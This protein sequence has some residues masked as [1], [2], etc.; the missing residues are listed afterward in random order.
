MTG[1][2]ESWLTLRE[3]ADN[4][5]R[6]KTLERE[7]ESLVQ[8]QREL[9][10]L[11]LGC[12]TG[13]NLRYLLPRLGH[14]Q[15]WTLFDNDAALLASLPNLLSQWANTYGATMRLENN[16]IVLQAPGFDATIHTI[17]IDLAK[18]LP[19]LPL[20][21]A[22][23]VTGSALLDLTSR[24]W[25]DTLATLCVE[26]RCATLF[27]LNYDG[28]VHW[29]PSLID[30]QLVLQQLNEHQLRDKGFGAAMGPNAG[31]YFAQQL[32]ILGASVFTDKSD[33]ITTPAQNQLQRAIVDG[34]APAAIEQNPSLS[35]SVEQW[36][37]QRIQQIDNG[38]STL[39]VG[40][41]DVLSLPA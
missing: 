18:Q 19:S 10:I 13:S 21:S 30:D 37:M 1:F 31:A 23:L 4:A 20:G 17:A 40:H 35:T 7:L 34:W 32:Q 33:W 25:L 9:N 39:Q 15:H 27:V 22:D 26:N 29:T 14:Q 16:S 38:E 5:A 6:S 36:Q 12:G 41:L 24:Y 2:S 3:P 8:P 11:D 28:E